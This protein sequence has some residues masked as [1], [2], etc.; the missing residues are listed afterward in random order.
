MSGYPN[1][2]AATNPW[3][4]VE[5]KNIS[6]GEIDISWFIAHAEIDKSVKLR[7]ERTWK[8]LPIAI[9]GSLNSEKG[10]IFELPPDSPSLN[11]ETSCLFLKENESEFKVL[12][13]FIVEISWRD[14]GEFE[15][16]TSWFWFNFEKS[17]SVEISSRIDDNS[18][19]RLISRVFSLK[20]ISLE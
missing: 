20:S 5:S 6:A 16:R 7:S 3:G 8:C 12:F 4:N 13:S 2:F 11:L 15:K 14:S 1:I 10:V 18:I 19:A 9:L 17:K